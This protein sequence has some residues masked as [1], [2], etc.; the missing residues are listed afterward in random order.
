MN[1]LIIQSHEV[2]FSGEVVSA[3]LPGEMGSFTV[4][5]NHASL[6]S[7]L[8]AGSITY[9]TAAGSTE[10]V[11]VQGGVVDVDNNVISV[12]VY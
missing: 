5:K 10:S 4:L 6:L 9:T 12:C 1:L 2:L 11:E 3:T 8:S 7:A